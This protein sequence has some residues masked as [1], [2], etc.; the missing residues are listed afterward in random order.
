MVQTGFDSM[1]LACP[2]L[3]YPR[4]VDALL[5]LMRAGSAFTAFAGDLQVRFRVLWHGQVNAVV[6]L[7]ASIQYL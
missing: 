3:H 4:L 2:A 7:K 6:S 5:P 1:V